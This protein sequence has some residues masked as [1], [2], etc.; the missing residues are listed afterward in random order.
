[1]QRALTGAAIKI[2]R[3][4]YADYLFLFPFI[5]FQFDDIVFRRM[6]AWL[7]GKTAAVKYQ[8]IFILTSKNGKFFLSVS[9]I[10]AIINDKKGACYMK[11]EIKVI[12][13]GDSVT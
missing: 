2:I 7:I 3:I 8:N 9:R 11:E 1:M 10:L 5:L 12:A 6:H 13:L 4:K